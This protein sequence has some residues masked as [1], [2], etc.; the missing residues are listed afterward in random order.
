MPVL[1]PQ[2]LARH[3]DRLYRVAWALCGS[4]HDAEDLVQ[5]TFARVLAKPRTIRSGQ[6]LPYLLQA[7]R[8]THLSSRRAARRRPQ[9]VADA[10]ELPIADMRRS[11]DP[12]EA[13]QTRRLFATIAEL[14]ADFRLAL[15]AV[16]VAGLSH[17]E[18]AQLLCTREPTIATRVFRARQRLSRAL[19]DQEGQRDREGP[20]RSRR[21]I[22]QE[23]A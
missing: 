14:P 2:E 17:R 16:D 18:A 21:L 15:V 5:E 19:E 6:E 23:H 8:N 11:R 9:A 22:E 3:I 1:D 20:T 13:L 4:S 12:V 7:L 10:E